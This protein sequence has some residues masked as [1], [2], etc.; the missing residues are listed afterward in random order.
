MEPAPFRNE[1]TVM[2]ARVDWG[3]IWLE[4]AGDFRGC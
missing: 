2:E 4:I 3:F 1:Y